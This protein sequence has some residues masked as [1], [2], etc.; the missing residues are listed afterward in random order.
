MSYVIT[1][2][3]LSDIPSEQIKDSNNVGGFSEPGLKTVKILDVRYLGP[4]AEKPTERNTYKVTIECIEG[5]SDV[6]ARANLTYWLKD[7]DTNLINAKTLGTMQS[8]GKAIFGKDFP[9][10]TV[11]N[12][13][14][15]IGAVVMADINLSKPDDLGR[16][17]TRV[18]RY[19]QA[20]S[21]FSA[22]SEIE[23][24]YRELANDSGGQDKN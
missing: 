21:D 10:R 15:I 17:F 20:S 7:K 14:D 19:E 13:A 16:V 18:F 2:W 11:P 6:G 8:L 4:T 23:Q 24:S 3:D 22:F 1:K 5:G 9:D 12:P